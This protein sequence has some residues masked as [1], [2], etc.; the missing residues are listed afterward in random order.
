MFI[1]RYIECAIE[2][3]ESYINQNNDN[4]KYLVF[5][6]ELLEKHGLFNDE[7]KKKYA[8]FN[9]I[10]FFL[11]SRI[12][13][14]SDQ[15]N[16]YSTIF[17]TIYKNKEHKI[18]SN[19]KYENENQ[20]DFD[21]KMNNIQSLI[22]NEEIKYYDVNKVIEKKN[23]PKI[24][25]F[26]SYLK[27]YADIINVIAMIINLESFQDFVRK[28]SN[29][30]Y[31]FG[32]PL[33]KHLASV[34]SFFIPFLNEIGIQN[35]LNLRDEHLILYLLEKHH[36]KELIINKIF[37][38]NNISFITIIFKNK[39]QKIF[40]IVFNNLLYKKIKFKLLNKYNF[41]VNGQKNLMLYAKNITHVNINQI[42]RMC[43]YVLTIKNESK[44]FSCTEIINLFIKSD[45][46]TNQFIRYQQIKRIQEDAETKKITKK[47]LFKLSRNNILTVSSELQKYTFHKRKTIV[48]T[49]VEE[50]FTHM[51]SLYVDFFRNQ[52]VFNNYILECELFD[53]I[54][55][56]HRLYIKEL[57]NETVQSTVKS[58]DN[59]QIQILSIGS[60][61][62]KALK[63]IEKACEFIK[64]LQFKEPKKSILLNLSKSYLQKCFEKGDFILI[65]LLMALLT[66]NIELNLKQNIINFKKKILAD[67]RLS[68][69][70]KN[71][72]ID[73]YYELIQKYQKFQGMP[74]ISE[75]LNNVFDKKK[76]HELTAFEIQN[77]EYSDN[78]LEYILTFK[79]KKTLSEPE[80][81]NFIWFI[82]K[83][84]PKI[85]DHEWIKEF[86]DKLNVNNS[87]LKTIVSSLKAK[88]TIHSQ[89]E[90]S[91]DKLSDF[92]NENEVSC[93]KHTSSISQNLSTKYED[94][95]YKRIKNE[96]KKNDILLSNKY[97]DKD[98]T[99]RYNNRSFNQNVSYYQD[100]STSRKEY[101]DQMYENHIN[102][103]QNNSYSNREYN[104]YDNSFKEPYSAYRNYRT[105]QYD[106]YK[107][108]GKNYRGRNYINSS[109]QNKI[110][111]SY[112]RITRS[113]PANYSVYEKNYNYRNDYY[114]SHDYYSENR[115]DSR[116]EN[117]NYGN[118]QYANNDSFYKYSDNKQNNRSN[119]QN[120]DYYDSQTRYYSANSQYD[121]KNRSTSSYSEKRQYQMNN[122]NRSTNYAYN[123]DTQLERTDKSNNKNTYSSD[124]YSS[125]WNQ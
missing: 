76:Y 71:E 93:D 67:S 20:P 36:N 23:K 53:Y 51:L 11:Q 13:Y 116:Y 32:I 16:L 45:H 5:P 57:K 108:T 59:S 44:K 83:F 47:A 73:R 77:M 8:R 104:F 52:D 63:K 60:T 40:D 21:H 28:K 112:S 110:Y 14:I 86:C 109:N 29:Q 12:I 88:L 9:T 115:S 43:D 24:F 10:N 124:N 56:N 90:N 101:V 72:L 65:D 31:I 18:F 80:I 2:E 100:P 33:N 91:N 123:K 55:V 37:Y 41:Y 34:L 89:L 54:Q 87:S 75:I 118:K 15:M 1:E 46:F 25:K 61:N 74:K 119:N 49:I 85:Q 117:T 82:N 113:K 3:N 68:S 97:P 35:I 19:K 99:S 50:S 103:R 122:P 106:D 92:N 107:N 111:D 26:L 64:I 120:Y 58:E 39:N 121:E 95:F 22:Y 66:Y 62:V 4:T 30:I 98:S 70:F 102:S 84:L 6:R 105:N 125:R 81:L 7:I 94:H 78:I 27:R 48:K 17:S 42:F 114:Q 79:V 38:S 69:L 96:H